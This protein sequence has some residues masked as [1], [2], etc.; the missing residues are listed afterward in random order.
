MTRCQ[1]R[2]LR[3]FG[4]LISG[5][6]LLYSCGGGGAPPPSSFTI[7]GTVSGLAGGG[8]V[9][10]L[11]NGA[12]TLTVTAN[13]MF[14][15]P[16]PLMNAAAYAVTVK[17][18]PASQI[19]TVGSGSGTVAS[20][21]ITDVTVSCAASYT[22]GGVITGLSSGDQV[23][24]LDNGA[25]GL[26]VTANGAF[27]FSTA[28]LGAAA[29]AVTVGTAPAGE[30]CTVSNG[31]GTVASA[32]VTNAIVTCAAT[33][34]S[35]SNILLELGHTQGI[36]NLQISATRLVS[37]DQSGH[38]VLWNAAT[39]ALVA[40][41][42]A[43]C[44]SSRCGTLSE[45]VAAVAL[46]GQT[47]VIETAGGLEISAAADGH[48]V[49][50][51]PGP[52]SWWTLASDG[53]YIDTGSPTALQAWSPSGQRLYSVSGDYT[54]AIAYAAPGQIQV[55]LG[56][57]GTNVIQTVATATGTATTG[58]TF[59]GTFNEWFVD[60]SHFQAVAG[61]TVYTYLNTS[62][63]ADLTSLPSINDL[64]GQGNWFW[65]EDSTPTTVNVYAVGSSAAPTATYP[66][67]DPMASGTT[68]AIPAQSSLPQFTQVDLSGTTLTSTVV[69]LP[70][71]SGLA[72]A[73]TSPT[74][75]FLGG[76]YGV[77][78]DGTSSVTAPKFVA[79]G[80]AFSIAGGGG[81]AAIATASGQIFTV[82]P[83]SGLVQ[84]TLDFL[85]SGLAMSTDG[86]VLA[87]LSAE[88]TT[89]PAWPPVLQIY[90]LPS[91]ALTQ[92]FGGSGSSTAIVGY[93][94]AGSGTVIAQVTAPV[95]GS[96]NPTL[97]QVTD[98]ATS[99]VIWS[100]VTYLTPV[101]FSPDGTIFAAPTSI[102]DTS[103]ANIYSNGQLTGAV[104]NQAVGWI[105]DGQLLVDNF[106]L[107]A[108]CSCLKYTGSTIYSPT[109][110]VLATP[111]L[112]ALSSIQMVTAN[113]VYS[114]QF[115]AI[116]SLTTGAAKWTGTPPPANLPPIGAVAGTYAVVVFGTQVVAEPY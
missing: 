42:N 6:G 78:F 40:S 21:A 82:N 79:L 105:D 8:Q 28:L 113:T 54:S 114:P 32:N 29:Y 76:G 81:V 5:T 108:G 46:A 93:S 41:G 83:Q 109:G 74:Q 37:E 12:D 23:I 38:W 73:A 27:S 111:A 13:G 75:W 57:A 92:S 25:D 2:Y 9:V 86:T 71:F 59:Q 66:G 43:G 15:F 10:L 99:A 48:V 90:S 17:T 101:L 55:A 87:A 19:C 35:G 89:N 1:H 16:T 61:T 14:T 65:S 22:I 63:Q 33:L 31:S 80:A 116:Y 103:S 68:L 4:L 44:L 7:G 49:V 106:T 100:S 69:P 115:N 58:P 39:D 26:T 88:Y 45:P 18:A 30:T 11:D 62:V 102:G 107:N 104:T 51:I 70:G 77:V 91:G 84:T 24:L 97:Q 52:I 64:G 56:P 34:I 96:V 60:G 72:Y 112:P 98:L 50:T 67:N 47:L 3:L 36:T 110:A 94:L 85:S 95:G 20:A 53:S